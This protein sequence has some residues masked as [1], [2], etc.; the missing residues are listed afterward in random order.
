[1]YGNSKNT[2]DGKVC[3]S[4]P[5]GLDGRRRENKGFKEKAKSALLRTKV[6]ACLDT[7][8]SYA[9]FILNVCASRHNREQVID[10]VSL[11]LAE[12]F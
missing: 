8:T 11:F 6:A 7:K 9:D 3:Q 2:A 10:A 12:G 1:M 5:M 4:L